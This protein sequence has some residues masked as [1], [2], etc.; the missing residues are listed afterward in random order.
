MFEHGIFQ[1]L[2]LP[3][4]L[5]LFGFLEPCSIGSSLVVVKQ[6]EG[7]SARQKMVRMLVLSTFLVRRS[8]T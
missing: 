3:L 5:G 6:M 8:A 2:G 1:T 7:H 4:L